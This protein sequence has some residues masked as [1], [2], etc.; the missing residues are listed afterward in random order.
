MSDPGKTADTAFLNSNDSSTTCN[1]QIHPSSQGLSSTNSKEH[2]FPDL[3]NFVNQRMESELDELF[4]N[5]Y[6][7]AN[8]LYVEVA[9]GFP[10]P[11]IVY[12]WNKR[13]KRNF[14][15]ISGNRRSWKGDNK[16]NVG[17]EWRSNWENPSYD[18]YVAQESRKRHNP[19]M[20]HIRVTYPGRMNS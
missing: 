5:R 17:S 10:D 15:Y 4:I 11:V 8:K 16:R 2:D 1:V 14:D 13:P 19:A 3:T 6:T 12:P 20:D 18:P 7:M 9:N